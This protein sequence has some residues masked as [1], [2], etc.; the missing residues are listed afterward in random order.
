MF[1]VKDI[2]GESIVVDGG[3]VEKY[4]LNDMRGHP[5]A[6]DYV[7]TQVREI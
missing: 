2:R 6:R 3:F 1:R 5:P 7:E 4:R